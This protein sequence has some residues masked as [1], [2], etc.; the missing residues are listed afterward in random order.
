MKPVEYIKEL[1]AQITYLFAFC[2]AINELDL[3]AALFNEF[4]GMQDA[5]WSTAITAHEVFS[6]LQS[7]GQRESPLTVAEYR[8]MLCLYAQ[9][10]EAG[11]IYEGLLNLMGVVQLKPYN[12]WPFQD[13]VRV[14]STPHRII[15]PNANAMFRRLAESA[16]SIGLPR[17]AE[18]LAITFND[19]VRNGLFHADYIIRHDGLRLRRRNGGH[20]YVISHEDIGGLVT[21]GITFF[22]LFT[23]LQRQTMESFRPAKRIVGRF[24]ANTPMAH[25]VEFGDDGAFS[26]SSNSVGSETDAAYE[27]QQSI[28]AYLDGRVF[29]AYAIDEE[30]FAPIQD[31]LRL[32]GFDPVYAVLDAPAFAALEDH[33]E[34]AGLWAPAAISDCRGAQ[35]LATPFG[36]LRWSGSDC[37]DAV[38][39]PVE[40]V[41]FETQSG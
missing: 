40:E 20:A 29:A 18:L 16:S 2:R 21:I 23:Q 38:L 32:Y 39:P 33:I 3:A 4:R 12:L 37:L 19:D 25:T 10:S 5:G 17:L 9:L 1:N 30:S 13:M 35:L 8:Q 31:S 36:F 26:I 24:S 34:K 27:R 28:N 14:R 6:E 15:G 22:D 41:E 11:G 7:L